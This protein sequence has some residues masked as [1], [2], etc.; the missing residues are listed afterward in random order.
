PCVLPAATP[1][2]Q[3]VQFRAYPDTMHH[4]RRPYSRLPYVALG[5]TLVL[6]I[7]VLRQDDNQQDARRIWGVVAAV[8][9]ETALVVGRQL[10]AFADNAR[11]LSALDRTTLDLRRQEERSRALI[12]RSSDITVVINAGGVLTY[13]SPASS[14]VL[15]RPPE[16]FIG[17]RARD[18]VRPEDRA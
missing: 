11:L 2:I 16:D 12:Q 10:L 13:V 5:L 9:V 7:V 14:R 6:L 4:R 3:E 18:F 17:H 1:R 15:G 8:V